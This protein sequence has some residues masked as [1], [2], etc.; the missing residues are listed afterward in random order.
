MAIQDEARGRCEG[1][2]RRKSREKDEHERKGREGICKST[3]TNETS[4]RGREGRA[5]TTNVHMAI[6]RMQHVSWLPEDS[7]GVTVVD[8]AWS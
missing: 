6:S 5:G 7:E 3:S 1:R 4:R 8:S 2:E